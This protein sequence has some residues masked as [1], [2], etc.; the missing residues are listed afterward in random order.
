MLNVKQPRQSN[1][2]YSGLKLGRT[3]LFFNHQMLCSP[4]LRNPKNW[5]SSNYLSVMSIYI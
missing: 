1:G 5:K 3:L 2:E 4:S